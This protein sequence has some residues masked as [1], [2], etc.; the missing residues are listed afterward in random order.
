MLGDTVFTY[1][2]SSLRVGITQ[3]RPKQGIVIQSVGDGWW[4]TV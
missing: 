1:G 4:R 2:N 3:L